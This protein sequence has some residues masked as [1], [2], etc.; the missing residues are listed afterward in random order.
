M[1]TTR[2]DAIRRFTAAETDAMIAAGIVPAS[3]RAVVG[4]GRRFTVAEYLAPGRSRHTGE[5][6][7]N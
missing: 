3:E 2:A 5:R 7:T 6:G 1:T 4:A